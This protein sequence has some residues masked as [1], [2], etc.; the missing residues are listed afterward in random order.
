MKL[1]AYDKSYL[2]T[3]KGIFLILFGILGMLQIIGSIKV[4]FILFVL[5]ISAI[6]TVSIASAALLKKTE[7]KRWSIFTGIINLIFAL[8]LILKMES[9]SRD[10]LWMILFWI[11]F[12]V[13][14]ELVEAVI[15]FTR[16]NA[17][18]ALF[19]NNALISALFGYFLYIVLND[20]VAFKVF[21]LGI[22]AII[23]GSTNLLSSYILSKA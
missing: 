1:K 20:F 5:L 18:A 6:G 23:F 12:F 3:F 11:A 17:F 7:N 14:T 2:L 4:L 19:L 10:Y 9:A 16:K 8:S 21:N 22:A 15:L 13:I